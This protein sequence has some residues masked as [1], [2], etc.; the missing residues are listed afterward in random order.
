MSERA[1]LAAALRAHVARRRALGERRVAAPAP[2]ASGAAAPRPGGP[3]ATPLLPPP[4]P[5]AREDRADPAPVAA[6]GQETSAFASAGRSAEPPQ[7]AASA[8]AEPAAPPGAPDRAAAAPAGADAPGDDAAAAGAAPAAQPAAQPAALLSVQPAGHAPARGEPDRARFSL[9]RAHSGDGDGDGDPGNRTP[10]SA[11]GPAA[12][13]LPAALAPGCADLAALRAAVAVCR[14][15]GLCETRTQTVFAD[16]PLGRARVMFVGEAPG[17]HED[18][19][20]VPFVGKA[21]A[22]LTDIIT[23]GMGLRRE[24][25]VIANVLKCRPPDNRDPRPDEKELC[26]PWLD[27][28]IELVDPEVLIPLG[29]HA[30]NHLLG[31][32]LSMG[33]LRGRVHAV[34]GRKVVPTFHPAYLLRSPGEKQACWE[35]IQLAM[36][37]LGL[38]RPER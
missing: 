22:L 3:A 10:R 11:G 5:P 30:A 28:Q 24:E 2:A 29:R 33:R 20:G 13:G 15:C 4:P 9:G 12:P 17:F 8:R 38:R 26:T 37:I 25:V 32:D 19:E 21:G 6:P 1:L 14:A 23:K 36:G 27:R 16:G 35:D 31:T 18:R 7:G 34:R